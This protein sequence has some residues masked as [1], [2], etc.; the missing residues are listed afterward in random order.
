MNDYTKGI[1][2]G[3]SLI[4]C[5]FMFVSAKSQSKN[6]GDVTVRSISV[7]NANGKKTAF[8][9]TGKNGDATAVLYDV[10][11]WGSIGWQAFGDGT[12]VSDTNKFYH[13]EIY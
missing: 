2:T 10:R 1:L 3:A 9:G 6:L 7:F 5:F 11:R 8:I 4:L 12:M 13:Q